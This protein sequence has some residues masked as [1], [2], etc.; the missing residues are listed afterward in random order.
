MPLDDLD[1][2]HPDFEEAVQAIAEAVIERTRGSSGF[3]A[4][5]GDAVVERYRRE[6]KRHIIRT[7]TWDGFNI[8]TAR[9][10]ALFGEKYTD[11]R[12]WGR[13]W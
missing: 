6:K 5:T 8:G 3:G 9:E 10:V 13:S 4:T 12:A 7:M 1:V 11:S 2:E